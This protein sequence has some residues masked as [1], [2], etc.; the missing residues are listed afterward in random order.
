MRCRI[1]DNPPRLRTRGEIW[2]VLEDGYLISN[3]GRVW[4]L[5]RGKLLACCRNTSGYYRFRVFREGAQ[6]WH[7]VH[8]KVV[9]IFGDRNGVVFGSDVVSLVDNGLSIDHVNGFKKD[10]AIGNL[11][12]VTHSENCRRFHARVRA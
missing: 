12:I 5:K 9:E 2:A 3:F 1:V 8:I 6:K 4:S 10:N 7:F 11:E